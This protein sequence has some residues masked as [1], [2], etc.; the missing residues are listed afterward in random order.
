MAQPFVGQIISV[1]FN[2][3][4]EGWFLCDGSLV[5]I[6]SYTT[7]YQLLGT[8]YGGDGVNTFA[9]PDLRGRA[10][11]NEGQ[12]T[13]LP[14]YV[15]GQPVG[16]E[17]VTLQNNQIGAHTHQFSAT[18][19]QGTSKTPGPT[20]A[21]A[22]NAQPAVEMYGTVAPNTSLSPQAI[23]AVGSSQPHENRQPYLAINYIIAWAGVYPSQQ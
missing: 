19:Q 1:A 3:T 4:P 15:I 23:S 17:T 6:A 20:L 11:L 9:L 18:T 12:G 13:G 2:F 10:P 14:A 7:L 21:L 8:T 5:P 22:Q 16:S